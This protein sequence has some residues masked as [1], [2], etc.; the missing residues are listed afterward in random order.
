MAFKKINTTLVLKGISM[1]E[2]NWES[3]ME[4]KRKKRILEVE[5]RELRQKELIDGLKEDA[6]DERDYI[7]TAL[8]PI[9][10]TKNLFIDEAKWKE[11]IIAY[12]K[13]KKLN[14]KLLS[15]VLASAF[16]E[17][18][19]AFLFSQK[20]LLNLL[21]N[22]KF[23]DRKT[24][25]GT[26]YA[27]FMAFVFKNSYFKVEIEPEN[28]RHARMLSL[29]RR[30]LASY[31]IYAYDKPEDLV[32]RIVDD[33]QDIELL[34]SRRVSN[35]KQPNIVTKNDDIGSE[36]QTIPNSEDIETVNKVMALE[37]KFGDYENENFYS[38]AQIVRRSGK[39]KGDQKKLFLNFI[40]DKSWK[41]N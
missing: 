36:P 16:Y 35:N 37:H 27:S 23:I 18:K 24:V 15:V 29:D 7:K 13:S 40:K 8:T 12:K 20:I 31:E 38:I 14:Y 17:H 3:Q 22:N 26:E 41:G 19:P 21:E 28:K 25:S 10:R 2:L 30:L 39:F 9:K 5:E 1:S 6:K 34:K 11:L 4:Q 33:Y 32:K